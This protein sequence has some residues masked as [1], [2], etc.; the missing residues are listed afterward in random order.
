VS[1]DLG[2]CPVLSIGCW[3]GVSIR[4]WLLDDRYGLLPREPQR[5]GGEHDH[6][7]PKHEIEQHRPSPLV[8]RASRRDGHPVAPGPDMEYTG[9]LVPDWSSRSSARMSQGAGRKAVRTSLKALLTLAC[10]KIWASVL[11]AGFC[12][13]L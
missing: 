6:E 9:P 13:V 4:S 3:I 7:G 12:G 8:T 2:S 10:I 1:D 11:F 5:Q